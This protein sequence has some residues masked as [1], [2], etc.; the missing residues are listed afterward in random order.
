MDHIW[1][2]N[3]QILFL[4]FKV[5]KN[6][7]FTK[8]VRS[9]NVGCRGQKYGLKGYILQDNAITHRAIIQEI[10]PSNVIKSFYTPSMV[11][12]VLYY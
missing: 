3:P 8:G 5:G 2:A 10:L 9:G 11:F 12:T 6:C 4:V 7:Q 1:R